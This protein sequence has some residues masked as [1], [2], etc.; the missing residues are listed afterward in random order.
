MDGK[1]W[2]MSTFCQQINNRNRFQT[3]HFHHQRSF[4][5]EVLGSFSDIWD[6]FVLSSRPRALRED[7]ILPSFAISISP[8]GV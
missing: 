7:Q 8:G 5:A 1:N 3:R 4:W 6:V 2:D